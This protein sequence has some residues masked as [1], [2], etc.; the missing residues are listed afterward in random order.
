M[1]FTTVLLFGKGEENGDEEM[2]PKEKVRAQKGDGPRK[3]GGRGRADGGSYFGYAELN[4][5]TPDIG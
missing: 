4:G 1:W 2:R 5:G 3:G